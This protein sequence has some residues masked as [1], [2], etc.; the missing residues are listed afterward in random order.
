MECILK[1][2]EKRWKNMLWHSWSTHQSISACWIG[3]SFFFQH[4]LLLPHSAWA[5]QVTQ[6]WRAVLPSLLLMVY[7][8]H[9]PQPEATE[10]EEVKAELGISLLLKI[11]SS[12]LVLWAASYPGAREPITPVPCL[13][14]IPQQS[15]SSHSAG[16]RARPSL[17]T[18]SSFLI[19]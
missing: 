4:L 13:L 17:D 5:V 2:V 10:A 14:S 1:T 18:T 12:Y 3:N 11:R 7:T 15:S 16:K 19:W 8:T 6:A 9:I